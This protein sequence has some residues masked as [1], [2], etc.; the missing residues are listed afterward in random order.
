MK[1]TIDLA[2][3]A[4]SSGATD[5][6][7]PALPWD[8]IGSRIIIVKKKSYGLRISKFNMVKELDR[9]R[10]ELDELKK[11]IKIKQ[12]KLDGL[13]REEKELNLLEDELTAL[14][15]KRHEELELLAAR[16]LL[17]MTLKE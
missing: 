5:V 9:K 11:E 13:I 10:N 8:R 4:H 6:V 12:D 14:I 1:R 17:N 7:S 16:P 3:T 2:A 15:V